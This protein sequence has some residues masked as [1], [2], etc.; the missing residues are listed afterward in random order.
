M[1]LLSFTNPLCAQLYKLSRAEK[2]S[3]LSSGVFNSF[4]PQCGLLALVS[5]SWRRRRKSR[6]RRGNVGNNAR[7]RNILV[8][9]FA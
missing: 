9:V 5:N 2:L 3:T 1:K 8:S 4:I 6:C 7:F